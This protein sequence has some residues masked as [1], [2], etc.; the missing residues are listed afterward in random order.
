MSEQGM[1]LEGIDVQVSSDFQQAMSD[2]KKQ[3]ENSKDQGRRGNMD[4]EETQEIGGLGRGTP[5]DIWQTAGRL[6]LVA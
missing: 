5:E 6:D 2:A 3:K 1:R 4:T